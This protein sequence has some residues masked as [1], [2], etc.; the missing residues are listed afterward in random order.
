MLLC[1]VS[2]MNKHRGLQ[3]PY[4]KSDTVR[5]GDSCCW[6]F[7]F[8]IWMPLTSEVLVTATAA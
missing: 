6:G 5:G 2:D 3:Q 8:Y 7:T 1:L 4:W